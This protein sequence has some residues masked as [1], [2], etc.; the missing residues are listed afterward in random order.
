MKQILLT[1]VLYLSIASY[2]CIHQP[3]L[4]AQTFNDG[5]T[6]V[7]SYQQLLEDYDSL[8]SYIKQVSPIIYFNQEVRGINF[9]YTAK[10][11]RK[12]IHPKTSM[13]DYLQIVEKTLNA[14]Q[15]G[16]S[17]ILGDWHL[18]ILKNNWIPNGFV[19]GIDSTAITYGYIYN[20]YLT[21]NFYTKL[22]LNLVYTSGEYYNLL[23]FS[24]KGK[25]FPASLKLISCNGTAIHPFVAQ[26]TLFVSPLR[27][28]RINNRP[29]N[30]KFYKPAAMY[31]N[32][33]LQLVFADKTNKQY[34]LNIAK[35]DTIVFLQEKNRE[36]GYN[37]EQSPIITHYF[38]DKGI[39]YAKMPMMVEAYGDSLSQRL[40]PVI[41][42]HKVKAIIIDI[43]GNP[44][45][46]DNT[47]SN[48]L[49]KVVKDTL[50]QNV[51]VG[52][53]FSPY[54]QR[55]FNINRDS[56]Q[57]KESYSFKVPVTTLQQPE[58][59]YISIPNFKFVVPDSSNYAFN[60]KIYILQDRFIYSSASNLSNLA[61]NNE[62]LV[63]IGETPDLLG[64]LQTNP[65]VLS[66]PHSKIIFRIEPQIDFTNSKNKRDIFQNNV[67]YPLHYSIEQLYLRITTKEDVF[68][69]DFLFNNDPFFKKVIALESR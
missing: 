47:Y 35:N 42:K 10:L 11:L 16:H 60:G 65:T 17:N 7:L 4:K 14:A 20:E 21:K 39:F 6:P 57:N 54:N 26:Q 19:K 43:R 9:A 34:V 53:N 27:W 24:Y 56:V 55:F 28:D 22:S 61:A 44:G 51:I 38:E 5:K 59:Y 67:E 45:G 48:F 1:F 50:T 33:R 2:T 36:Y 49:K 46:S 66:L 13:G 30:E 64:G 58:M 15:D 29:Y 62:Q 63:S 3:T 8:V 41:A 69:K 31:K 18:D 37:D 40:A 23:P 32:G 12:H 68:G 25:T 52:R